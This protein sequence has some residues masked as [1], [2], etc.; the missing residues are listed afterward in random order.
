M[1]IDH[2]IRRGRVEPILEPDAH[3]IDMLIGWR[4]KDN[5]RSREVRA[6][7]PLSIWKLRRPQPWIIRGQ[8]TPGVKIVLAERKRQIQMEGFDAARDDAYTNAELARAAQCY[9]I[10]HEKRNL[11]MKRVGEISTDPND[12]VP[13]SWPWPADWWK[14]GDRIRELA[15]AGALYLAEADRLKR[16][17]EKEKAADVEKQ[18]LG[19]CTGIDNLYRVTPLSPGPHMIHA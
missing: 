13:I 19:C 7:Q 1:N 4:R 16:A 10:P 6:N 12:S 14:P 17:G 2:L 18:A 15:K 8:L 11:V 3:G 9:E 5:P